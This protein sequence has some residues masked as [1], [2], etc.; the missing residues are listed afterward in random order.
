MREARVSYR[1]T[2]R[3]D[4]FFGKFTLSDFETLVSP[5]IMRLDILYEI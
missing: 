4:F 3:S 5:H 2:R 1:S